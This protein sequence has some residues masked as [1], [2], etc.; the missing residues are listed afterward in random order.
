MS[1]V[2]VTHK[3]ARATTYRR[4]GGAWDVPDLDALLTGPGPAVPLGPPRDVLIDGDIRLTRHDVDDLVAVLA[5][6]L[7]DLGVGRHGVVAWQ[8]QN[9]FEAVLL[10]RACWRLGAAAAP[11]R[12]H[13]R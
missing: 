8:L 2:R 13:A 5:G 11:R 7:R 10:Y 4:P 9:G 6:G 3:H 1:P 12:Q